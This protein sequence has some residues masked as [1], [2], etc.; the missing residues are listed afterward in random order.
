MNVKKLISVKLLLVITLAS[1][2]IFSS[3]TLLS[4]TTSTL[5]SLLTAALEEVKDAKV[6]KLRAFCIGPGP[7]PITRATNLEDAAKVLNRILEDLGADVRIE[8]EAEFSELKWGPFAEKFFAEYKAGRAPDIVIGLRDIPVL[9][10]EGIIIPLDDHVAAFWNLT[11]FDIYPSLCRSVTWN[12]KIWG[13]PQD[14]TP[15]CIWY[16]KD[17]LRK[18]GYS[19]DQIARMLPPDAKGITLDVIVELAKKAKEAGLVEYGIVHRPS[20][21]DTIQ[22]YMTIFGGEVYDEESGKLVL[23]KSA[24]LKMFQWF[25]K[26]VDEGLIPKEPPSWGTI[27]SMFVEGKVFATF[28]SHVGTPSEWMAKYGLSEESFKNDLGFLAFPPAVPGAKPI[29]TLGPLPYLITS[30]CKY[31]KVAELILL[32]ATSPEAVAKHSIRTLRPVTRRSMAYHPALQEWP[33][34]YT[35]ETAKMLEVAEPPVIHPDWGKYKSI[36]YEHI[37]GVEAGILSPEAAVEELVKVLRA[38]IGDQVLIK[39]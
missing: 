22:I 15:G 32:L 30:Q 14:A 25:K 33:Y 7:M 2:L 4:N 31:P 26:M 12:G 21:G 11:Y 3:I 37:K 9:A 35:V 34:G 8:I 6:I 29:T 18:L 19:D 10:K 28:A 39:D 13:I 1:L 36:V 16:R 24:A 38:E 27:H 23:V 20:P 17:I 5:A